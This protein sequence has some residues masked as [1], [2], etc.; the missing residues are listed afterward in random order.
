MLCEI[1]KE[2]QA[3]VH[4][5]QVC[6]GDVK[7]M[8]IC[9][10]CARKSGFD[11]HSPVAVTDLLFGIGFGEAVEESADER[12]CPACHMRPSDFRKNSRL[13]CPDC[14]DSF[15]DELQPM[16]REMHK[17]LKHRG[18]VP[19]GERVSLD[20]TKLERELAR[21]V[22]DQNFEEAAVLRDRLKTLAPAECPEPKSV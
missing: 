17:N 18:K 1:C 13:G 20:R 19:A 12:A 10:E 16:L 11:V 9:V 3:T 4:F 5:K 2:N 7:E 22:A 8:A 15:C 6:N 14:Y 21:A